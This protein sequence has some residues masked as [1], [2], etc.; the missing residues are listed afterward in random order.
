MQPCNGRPPTLNAF[1]CTGTLR[2]TLCNVDETS[3]KTPCNSDVSDL[4]IPSVTRQPLPCLAT[5]SSVSKDPSLQNAT[6]VSES[7][8]RG[9]LRKVLR[10]LPGAL[11]GQARNVRRPVQ[12]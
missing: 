10:S 12:S 5:V 11:K 6:L 8:N 7:T 2:N 1:S 3:S 9:P 4:R